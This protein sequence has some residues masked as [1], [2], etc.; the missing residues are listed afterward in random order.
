MTSA[1]L[2]ALIERILSLVSL[3]AETLAELK[4][5]NANGGPTDDQ[6]KVLLAKVDNQNTQIQQAS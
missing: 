3:A 4:T 2:A 6:L 5:L 1:T